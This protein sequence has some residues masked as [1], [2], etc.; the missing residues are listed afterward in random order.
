MRQD[1]ERL[2]LSREL[3]AILRSGR[4]DIDKLTLAFAAVMGQAIASAR[5]DV[6][7]A[8]ALGDRELKVK[9]QIKLESMATARRIYQ[10]CHRQ[11]TGRSAWDERNDG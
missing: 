2:T 3:H 11:V 6:E 9:H 8:S 7:L 4:P 1:A 10:M 5:R